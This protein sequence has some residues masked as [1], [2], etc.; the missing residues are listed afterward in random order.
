MPRFNSTMFVHFPMSTRQDKLYLFGNKKG[1]ALDA[2]QRNS[3]LDSQGVI[4][5]PSS[6]VRLYCI[7]LWYI[8]G[9]SFSYL[10]YQVSV[11]WGR[12]GGGQCYDIFLG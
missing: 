4:K 9:I 10:D 5:H 6:T 1:D 12:G 2:M 7:H 11:T 3:T 8:C